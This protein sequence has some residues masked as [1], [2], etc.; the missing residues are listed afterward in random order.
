MRGALPL[1]SRLMKAETRTRLRLT[2]LRPWWENPRG[3][4]LFPALIELGLAV[5]VAVVGVFAG[6][7]DVLA[8]WVVAAL[9]FAS[10]LVTLRFWRRSV[11]R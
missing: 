6:F 10:G 4:A 2:L 1:G 7:P 8:F 11:P 5:L 3:L 9:L